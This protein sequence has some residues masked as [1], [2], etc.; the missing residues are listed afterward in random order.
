ML[1]VNLS[2]AFLSFTLFGLLSTFLDPFFHRV[3]LVLLVDTEALHGMW[4]TLY[5]AP[6]APLTRFNNTVVMGSFVCGL[7][8]VLPVYLGMRAFVV[9]YRSSVGETI[10]RWKVYQVLSQNV[11]VRWYQKVRDLG[12]MS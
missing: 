12:G 5:N 8:L 11:I 4:T 9:A 2:A 1:N 3:G 6:L 10:R 7:F